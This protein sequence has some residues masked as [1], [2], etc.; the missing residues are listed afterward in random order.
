MSRIEQQRLTYHRDVRYE[1]YRH[2]LIRFLLETEKRDWPNKDLHPGLQLFIESSHLSGQIEKTEGLTWTEREIG[3]FHLQGSLGWWLDWHRN[4]MSQ[5]SQSSRFSTCSAALHPP[6]QTTVFPSTASF[7]DVC[8]LREQDVTGIS[9]YIGW[10][11]RLYS[12]VESRK[13]QTGG[14]NSLST[15]C[16]WTVE[17]EREIKC[18]ENKLVNEMAS[19]FSVL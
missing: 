7:R 6:C 19:C 4:P 10:R 14:P 12:S 1:Q 17:K 15:G 16:V 13:R 3:E 5:P 9:W 2:Y 11:M 18:V 8:P